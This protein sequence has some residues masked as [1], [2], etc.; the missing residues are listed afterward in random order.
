MKMFVE[1][2]TM[3]TKIEVW[4]YRLVSVLTLLVLTGFAGWSQAQVR[5][6][7]RPFESMTLT[8]DAFLRGE[9]GKPVV[10]AGELRIPRPGTDKLPAVVLMHASGGVNAGVDRWAQ[11]L[12]SLG[13]ATFI[14]D[15]FSGRGITALPPDPSNEAFL[16]V[17]VDA[18]RA[19]GMLAQHPRIDPNRIA[20][21]GFSM[22]GLVATY[23]SSERFWK[24]YG[25]ANVQFAA[26]ISLYGNCAVTYRDDTKVTGKPIRMFH[27][28]ADDIELIG[29]C[30]A[31]VARLKQAGA[32]VT[33]TEF[34]GAQHGFDWFMFK[35]PMKL[36]QA[37]TGVN[38]SL[39]EGERGQLVD[40]VTGKPYDPGISC[41]T[42]GGTLLYNE[43]S[44]AATTTAVK[45]FL[46]AA[47]GL[48]K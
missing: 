25:P 4:V 32:D 28:T 5:I 26:H 33:L 3:H 31:Y 39:A 2:R 48:N 11:D 46:S 20:V 27:G 40:T 16:W 43:A 14:V 29:P 35:E 19:L 9:V 24:A 13:V 34:A 8:S 47:F 22:G 38:C 7:V 23:T 18:Y 21:M 37:R 45:E 12:N 41:N 1:E 17:I 44:A 30:R 15:S 10:L 6:E 42:K 36:P